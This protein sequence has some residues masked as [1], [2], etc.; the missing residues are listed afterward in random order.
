M[1]ASG[2]LVIIWLFLTLALFTMGFV[3]GPL[4]AWLPDLFPAR[5]RYSGTS[6][7]FNVGGVLGGALTPIFAQMLASQGGLKLVGL[8]LS[9]AGALSLIGVAAAGKG[10]KIQEL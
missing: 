9:A 1:L 4:G 3:Y 7:A 6:V 8:Y 10:A 2:S 5:V